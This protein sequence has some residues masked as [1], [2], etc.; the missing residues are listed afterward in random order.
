[1]ARTGKSLV[2]SDEGGNSPGALVPPTGLYRRGQRDLQARPRS[3]RSRTT[4]ALSTNAPESPHPPPLTARTR[5]V[6]S[7]CG[8]SRLLRAAAVRSRVR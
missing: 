1:M 4:R 6:S 3:A 5:G 2:K 8:S 7:E